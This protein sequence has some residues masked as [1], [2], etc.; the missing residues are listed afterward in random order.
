M[1]ERRDELLLKM[2]DQLFNDINRHITVIWQ[3]ISV[4]VGSFAIF[5]L[6]EKKVIT[7]DIA[8]AIIILL[9]NWLIAHLYDAAYWYNRNLTMIANIERQFL[10]KKDLIDIHYYFGKHRPANKMLTH[11]KIQYALGIG[12]G[13]VVLM[14]HFIVIIFPGFNLPMSYFD[15]ILSLPYIIL[16]ISIIYLYFLRK[17]RKES[18][19]EFLKNSPGIDV[20]TKGIQYGVGHGY[21]NKSIV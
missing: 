10:M 2:Y 6:A 8:T 5:A 3:S 11:L 20:D 4:V 14:F 18:Y 15:P 19:E 12:L 9:V 7:L 13:G 17:N 1:S 21:K 16:F